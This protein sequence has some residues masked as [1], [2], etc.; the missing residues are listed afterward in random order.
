MV[1]YLE[2]PP[3]EPTLHAWIAALEDPLTDLVRPAKDNDAPAPTT[4]D[5][6]VALLLAD[7]TRMQRPLLITAERAIIGRPRERTDAFLAELAAG[8][9][10]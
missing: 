3:D 2:T 10:G 1:R 5:A 6:V 8:R 9:P 7:P 4:V